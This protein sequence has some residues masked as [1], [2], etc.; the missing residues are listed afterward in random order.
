LRQLPSP[1]G[2]LS[3]GR[4]LSYDTI[5]LALAAIIVSSTGFLMSRVDRVEDRLSR[6]EGNVN[7]LLGGRACAIEA[8]MTYIGKPQW[9]VD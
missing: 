9:F 5:A 6:L 8:R 1:H 4:K 7:D 3:C 2:R